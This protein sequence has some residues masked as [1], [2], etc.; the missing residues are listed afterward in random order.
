MTP[1]AEVTRAS[2]APSCVRVSGP[3]PGPLLL[4]RC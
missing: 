3:G 4:T 2:T 1:I